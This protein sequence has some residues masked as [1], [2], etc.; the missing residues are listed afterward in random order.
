MPYFQWLIK[1]V[2]FSERVESKQKLIDYATNI[3]P[4]YYWILRKLSSRL[5]NW[6]D[7]RKNIFL[8]F[9][10]S[11]FQLFM[12]GSTPFIPKS[13]HP[14]NAKTKTSFFFQHPENNFFLAN[15]GTSMKLFL[16]KPGCCIN[17][18]RFNQLPLPSTHYVKTIETV[19]YLYAC[20]LQNL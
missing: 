19:K 10:K 2:F 20:M 14:T 13:I 3:M 8:S 12:S 5:R 7:F 4:F 18:Y 6:Q 11:N 15:L 9:W 16:L 1:C 17:C